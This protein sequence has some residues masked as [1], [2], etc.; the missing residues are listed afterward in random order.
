LLYYNAT[1]VNQT[2]VSCHH[3]FTSIQSSNG[4]MK[5]PH[6]LS[7]SHKKK[8]FIPFKTEKAYLLNKGAFLAF[9]QQNF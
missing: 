4:I 1:Y 2:I 9:F 8:K 6:P 5:S 3:A 7:H